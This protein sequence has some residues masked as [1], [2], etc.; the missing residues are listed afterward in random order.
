MSRAKKK[1]SDAIFFPNLYKCIYEQ[2]GTINHFCEVTGIHRQAVY[3]TLYG[4]TFPNYILIRDVL[5]A[6]GQ[7]FEWL[8]KEA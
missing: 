3:D 6:T 7:T 5:D 4:R 2:F 1:T 8:F